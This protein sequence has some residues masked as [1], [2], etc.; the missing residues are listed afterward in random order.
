MIK[1]LV[2]L[3]DG[4]IHDFQNESDWRIARERWEKDGVL[5]IGDRE[6][7]A[8]DRPAFERIGEELNAML[9]DIYAP[10]PLKSTEE[11]AWQ[12]KVLQ[13]SQ[14]RL[15]AGSKPLWTF[16][17]Y[18]AAQTIHGGYNFNDTLTV[19]NMED[20]E[21]IEERARGC[22]EIADLENAKQPKPNSCGKCFNGW[23]LDG[24]TSYPCSCKPDLVEKVRDYISKSPYE[25]A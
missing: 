1:Y 20:W 2:A 14:Q 13:H 22:K 24:N 11:R 9:R 17:H 3:K 21:D 4:V 18:R 6:V 19:L 16:F 10:E 12:A 15:N 25:H 5:Q 7:L 23:I 8:E